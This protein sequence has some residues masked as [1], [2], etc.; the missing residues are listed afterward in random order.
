MQLIQYILI[1]IGGFIGL[2][3]IFR[4]ISLAVFNSWFDFKRKEKEKNQ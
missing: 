1:G 4:L 2:Y 3:I